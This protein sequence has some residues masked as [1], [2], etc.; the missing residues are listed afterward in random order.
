MAKIGGV[1][2]NLE[3]GVADVEK[4]ANQLSNFGPPLDK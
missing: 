1:V 3:Q 2:K 4:V